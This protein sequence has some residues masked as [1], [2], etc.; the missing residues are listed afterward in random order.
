MKKCAIISSFITNK[1]REKILEDKISYFISRGI[2]VLLV[3]SD[4][5][6]KYDG[7]NSYMVLNVRNCEDFYLSNILH[8]YVNFD[9]KKYWYKLPEKKGEKFSHC[10]YF[11]KMFQTT[12]SH[13]LKI[14]YDFIFFMEF[15]IMFKHEVFDKNILHNLDCSKYYFYK[16]A[17]VPEDTSYHSIFFYGNTLELNNLFSDY[18][19]KQLSDF[20]KTNNVWSVEHSLWTLLNNRD[21]IFKVDKTNLIINK[22][23][24]RDLYIHN[25]FSSNDIVEIFFDYNNK[26]Y[27][28]LASKENFAAN[29]ENKSEIGYELYLDNNLVSS[30]VLCGT[31]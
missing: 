13:C 18:N 7:V 25:L 22:S 16:W 14:G 19:L 6:K 24:N 30:K 8:L 29:D 11:L 23:L 20:V 28:F 12:I 10:V 31:L 17:D 5:I 9:N 15:D 3:S 26:K 27:F 2:D 21:S 4:Y 1:K